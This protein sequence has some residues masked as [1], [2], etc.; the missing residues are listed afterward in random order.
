MKIIIKTGI[1][2]SVQSTAMDQVMLFICV[3]IERKIPHPSYS[4]SDF[5]K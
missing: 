3:E 4:V 5:E 1:E 2:I